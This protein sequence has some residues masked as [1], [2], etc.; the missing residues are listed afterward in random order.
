VADEPHPAVST[1]FLADPKDPKKSQE[2]SQD[3]FDDFMATASKLRGGETKMTFS[4]KRRTSEFK[5]A[6]KT[7]P[8]ETATSALSLDR[9]VSDAAIKWQTSSSKTLSTEKAVAA[10]GTF[11]SIPY[12]KG[13]ASPPST[14]ETSPE[15]GER[16]REHAGPVMYPGGA[17]PPSLQRQ[18]SSV[19]IAAGD[20]G[21]GGEDS[22][23]GGGGGGGGGGE[24]SGVGGG[25]AAAALPARAPSGVAPFLAPYRSLARDSSLDVD[26]AALEATGSNASPG[27]VNV[28]PRGV[29]PRPS[30]A[31]RGVSPRP[32]SKSR[33]VDP[34]PPAGPAPLAPDPSPPAWSIA[35]PADFPGQPSALLLAATE[36]RPGAMVDWGL[37]SVESPRPCLRV[38]EPEAAA[39]SGAGPAASGDCYAGAAAGGGAVVVAPRPSVERRAHETAGAVTESMGFG[40]KRGKSKARPIRGVARAVASFRRAPSQV[41]GAARLRPYS[42]AA[43]A[44]SPRTGCQEPKYSQGNDSSNI[45]PPPLVFEPG[46]TY[47]F[48]SPESQEMLCPVELDV[49]NPWDLVLDPPP[50]PAP[51]RPRTNLGGAFGPRARWRAAVRIVIAANRLTAAGGTR[52]KIREAYESFKRQFGT[53]M[54][55]QGAREVQMQK[56]I[57]RTGYIGAGLTYA[58]FVYFV[59]VY[60]VKMYKNVGP[61]SELTFM[62]DWLSFLAMD[63]LVMDLP[64]AA[65]TAA[66]RTL[67]LALVVGLY[68]LLD[69]LSWFEL[70]DDECMNS[71][72]GL[73]GGLDAD[74]N[75]LDDV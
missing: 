52:Q 5:E 27:M 30:S 72:M 10:T 9:A 48:V 68:K 1:E 67:L 65:L 46:A 32:T 6:L 64:E 61:G 19:D 39:G 7:R 38:S 20:G 51:L 31:I 24:G 42:P 2:E 33:P 11:R 44:V 54:L 40:F 50:L 13:E 58:I 62:L 22:G 35:G 12:Y 43:Q 4:F 28:G 3:V 53:S 29:T 26:V 70:Y 15:A 21:G 73:E 66:F 55:N 74:D 49:D 63:T 56:L 41:Q 57:G 71:T 14:A 60:G 69:I 75:G 25:G 16:P 37:C 36:S 18:D 47:L 59:Y 45:P 17:S 8:L 34:T 23:V